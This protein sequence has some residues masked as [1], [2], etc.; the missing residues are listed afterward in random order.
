MGKKKLDNTVEDC[1]SRT[2]AEKWTKYQLDTYEYELKKTV[3]T[4][5]AEMSSKQHNNFSLRL[6]RTT[7]LEGYLYSFLYFFPHGYI[8]VCVIWW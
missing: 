4:A 5:L 7:E 8:K 1:S 2:K 6:A 3:Q